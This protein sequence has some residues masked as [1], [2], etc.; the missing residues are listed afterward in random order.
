MTW[1]FIEHLLWAR[2][3]VGGTADAVSPLLVWIHCSRRR[4]MR[5]GQPDDGSAYR[6]R[7]HSK[8][9]GVFCLEQKMAASFTDTSSALKVVNSWG[10]GAGQV[11]MWFRRQPLLRHSPAPLDGWFF[12][13]KFRGVLLVQ[14]KRIRKCTVFQFVVC[15]CFDFS[16]LA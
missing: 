14:F 16:R 1:L 15:F 7:A 5:S 3:W 10:Q 2:L 4:L 8:L 11:T 6:W 12:W 9:R 13:S